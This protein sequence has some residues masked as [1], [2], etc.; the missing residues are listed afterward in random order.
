MDGIQ[1]VQV[2]GMPGLGKSSIVRNTTNFL[3]ERGLY[4]SGILYINLSKVK[5]VKEVSNLIKHYINADSY[6]T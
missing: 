2:V 1:V 6:K 3:W 4:K 5:T